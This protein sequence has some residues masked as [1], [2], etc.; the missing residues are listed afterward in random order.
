MSP[1]IHRRQDGRFGASLTVN[2]TRHF[3]YG[4]T[5]AEAKAKLARLQADAIAF[6]GLPNAG[7]RTV[8]DLIDETLVTLKP[9]LKPRTFADYTAL[10]RRYVR[11]ALG[12]VRL[13]KLQPTQVQRLY[14]DIAG[15]N[16]TRAPAQVHL[17]LHRAFKL[18]VLW[19]WLPVNPCDR[20]VPP[21][22]QAPRKD[23]WDSDALGRFITDASG[24][25]YYPLWLVLLATG[26]R[27]G[28]ALGLTWTDVD[29]VRGVVQV[30]RNS[31][32]IDGVWVESTPKTRAGAREIGLPGDCIDV[33][34]GWKA[35]Q[36]EWRVKAGPSWPATGT[37]FTWPSGKTVHHAE[38]EHALDAECQ[39]LGLPKLTPHQL[40]HLNA[41]ILLDA[42]LAIPKVSARLGHAKPSITMSIYA[43][44]LGSDDSEAVSALSAVLRSEHRPNLSSTERSLHP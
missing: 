21:R 1:T 34:K 2:G 5:H 25:R 4:Q 29:L 27:L 28:E 15:R 39:R 10:A 40:R 14:Q 35:L 23:V 43:H 44:K 26:L 17:F 18:A 20:V 11:P 13:S 6:H 36:A 33:L 42:G 9:D 22:Y 41:S 30:R 37:V 38:I 12:S 3:V 8:S 19:G 16:L 24:H 7:T 31:Q 32:R